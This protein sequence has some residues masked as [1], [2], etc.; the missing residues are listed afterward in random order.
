MENRVAL[1][2]I[3][4]EQ[5]EASEAINRLLHEYSE[6]I[7]GR[8]GVPHRSRGISVIS[9]VI[10]APG[11]CISALSGKLGRLPN[12]TTKTIYSRVSGKEDAQ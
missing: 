11:D 6:Y 1:I 10:D 2:G 4:V 8:M 7:I 12:V 9:V 5:L 3:V